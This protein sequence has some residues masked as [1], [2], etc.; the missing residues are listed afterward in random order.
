ME[1]IIII[2][3]C[4]ECP[5][6]EYIEDNARGMIGSHYCQKN[7]RHIRHKELQENLIPYWCSLSDVIK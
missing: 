5:Y 1:K 2:K 4:E 7:R 6:Y 3:T